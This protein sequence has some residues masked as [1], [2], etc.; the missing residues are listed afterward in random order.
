MLEEGPSY[1]LMQVL[2]ANSRQFVGGGSDEGMAVCESGPE[3]IDVRRKP[4]KQHASVESSR[5]R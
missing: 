4:Q 1:L 2:A 3:S 5:S